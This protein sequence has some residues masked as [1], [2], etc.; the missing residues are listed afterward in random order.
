MK[1]E[2]FYCKALKEKH[3]GR[4]FDGDGPGR[5]VEAAG[6]TM[7]AFIRVFHKG[8]LVFLIETDNIQGAVLIT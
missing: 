8:N 2:R 4:E 3:L 5:A 7:P 1:N 6:A